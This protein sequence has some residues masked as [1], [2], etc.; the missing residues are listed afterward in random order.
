M[1]EGIHSSVWSPKTFMH[2]FRGPRYIQIKMGYKI[3]KSKILNNHVSWNLMFR[4][5]LLPYVV[6]KW[7]WIW[8]MSLNGIC[9]SLL[10]CS[11]HKSWHNQIL[12]NYNFNYFKF[13]KSDTPYC[14]AHNWAP[15]Y[16]TKMFLFSRWSYRYHLSN[17][18]C[19]SHLV[20]V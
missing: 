1:I 18:I 20:C 3:S 7:D 13:L 17:V 2:D 8:N 4:S 5:V 14:F 11:M 10:R 12:R 15:W 16:P 19:P 9:P 6:Q